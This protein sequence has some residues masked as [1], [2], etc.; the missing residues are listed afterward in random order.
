[1]SIGIM[2]RIFRTP[3]G[4]SSR[5]MLAVR[6]AD[7]ADDEGRG[8]WPTVARLS[9]ETDLSERTVQRLLR[10]FVSEGL[11]V[12][13]RENTGRRGEGTRYDFDMKVLHD[14]GAQKGDSDGCH[15]VGGDT[16]SPVGTGDIDDTTGDAECVH[17]C[18]HDTLTVIEPPIEPL[19][20]RDARERADEIRSEETSSQTPNEQKSKK[21]IEKDLKRVHPDWP[22]YVDD[23][24]AEVRKAWFALSDGEREEAAER[25]GDYVA[26][27]KSLGRQRFC[28]FSTY[29]SEKRWQK[30]PPP[31][32]A[33]SGPTRAPTFGKAWMAARLALLSEPSARLSPLTAFQERLIASGQQSRDDLIREKQ[34]KQ[35]WPKV[36]MMHEQAER[37]PR[38]GDVVSPEIASLGGR[39]EAV[40][41]GS[42][43][44]ESWKHEHAE[45][46]WPWLPDTGRH[47]WV[48]FPRLDGGKPS[49]ALSAFFEK[50]E[51]MQGRE[52]AE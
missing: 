19:T 31:V 5:K 35:G 14:L 1:M 13:V 11:L 10:E 38:K 39:F 20:E 16:V 12:V 32:K 22:T 21:A 47:E 44:W 29:L 40:R 50:L 26:A 27:V 4:T 45:R 3:F 7:F 28:R 17:G 49:D 37:D 15:H 9:R 24:D 36:N 48:Y 52:A 46:G 8:I 51:H 33:D 43:E 41:V 18:H 30:L 34:Q 42:D 2:S 23:S 6:L 25:M